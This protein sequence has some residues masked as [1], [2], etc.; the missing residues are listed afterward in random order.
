MR[1][2][3]Y[4]RELEFFIVHKEANWL[5]GL[6]YTCVLDMY[7]LPKKG[8]SYIEVQSLFCVNKAYT[9]ELNLPDGVLSMAVKLSLPLSMSTYLERIALHAEHMKIK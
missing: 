7:F 3:T 5:M 6:D 4:V 1:V 2:T 9:Y 8:Y